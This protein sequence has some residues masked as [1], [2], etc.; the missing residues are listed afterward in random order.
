MLNV[1]LKHPSVETAFAMLEQQVEALS[2]LCE[3]LVNANRALVKRCDQMQ[4]QQRD[5][6]RRNREARTAV[7]RV[8]TRLR[9][10]GEIR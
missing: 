10:Y 4:E 6:R 3:H 5:G 7:G 1:E 8:L 2:T 9:P